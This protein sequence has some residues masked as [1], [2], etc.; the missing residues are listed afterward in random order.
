MSD[1]KMLQAILDGQ[2]AVKE[3]LKASIKR[4]EEKVDRGFQKVDKRFEEVN[5]RIDKLGL[6]IARLED[7]SPTIEEFDQHEKRLTSLE[8]RIEETGS[9]L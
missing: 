3:E 2:S 4:L 7:D 9:S 1:T 8:S 6:Q 5:E